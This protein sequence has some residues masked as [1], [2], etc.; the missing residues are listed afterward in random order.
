MYAVVGCGECSAL[1]VIEGQPETSECPRCG[2]R[3]PFAR[4]K[5]FHTTDDADEAREARA[6]LLAR[7]QDMDEA[8]DSV[9]SFAALETQLDDAGVDDE[10]Y[11]EASGLDATAV[12]AAGERA[13]ESPGGSRSADEVVRAAI[14]ERDAP[15][16]EDVVA[17]ASE[18]DVD[19]ERA[20]RLLDKLVRAG[21]VSESRGAYRLV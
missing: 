3:R 1:W 7:R 13:S 10:T 21:E 6:R 15:T 12:E 9:D 20:E 5:Q 18:R 4:R 14:R 11:L 16:E 19:P 17:Y 8:F 2:A